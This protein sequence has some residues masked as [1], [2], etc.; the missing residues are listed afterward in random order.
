MMRPSNCMQRF[1]RPST[2]G[3]NACVIPWAARRAG[4]WATARSEVTIRHVRERWL[5]SPQGDPSGV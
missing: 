1:L 2:E 5:R 4:I 3:A